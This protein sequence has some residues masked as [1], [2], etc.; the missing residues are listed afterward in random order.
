MYSIS[1]LSK[2]INRW[3]IKGPLL[4]LVFFPM[5]WKHFTK[6]R[7]IEKKK[8]RMKKTDRATWDEI[9]HGC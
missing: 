8:S 9:R 1:Y 3:A 7:A 2:I 6:G 5:L 4:G